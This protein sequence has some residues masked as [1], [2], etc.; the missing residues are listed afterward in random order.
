MTISQEQ[1]KSLED[2]DD[3]DLGTR[4]YLVAYHSVKSGTIADYDNDGEIVVVW[5]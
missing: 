3:E 5:D 1:L 4:V 2:H